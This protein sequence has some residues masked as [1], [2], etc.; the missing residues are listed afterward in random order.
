M[1]IL[2]FEYSNNV[3]FDFDLK[4]LCQTIF[5]HIANLIDTKL[6]NCK[7]KFTVFDHFYIGKGAKENGF[8]SLKIHIL[9]GRSNTIKTQLGEYLINQLQKTCQTANKQLNLQISVEVLEIDRKFY[10]R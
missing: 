1:P 5:P 7:A 2:N 4:M 9:N 6:E 8:L 10:F 3:Q